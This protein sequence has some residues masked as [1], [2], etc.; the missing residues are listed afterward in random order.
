MSNDEI[1]LMGL[2][3]IRQA[4]DE[5]IEQQTAWLENSCIEELYNRP[6]HVHRVTR[7]LEITENIQGRILDIGCF[8]GYVTEKIQ[9]Q[10]GKKVICVD[11][12]KKALELAEKRGIKTHY[13]DLDEGELEFHDQSFDC[14]VAGGILNGTFDPDAVVREIHRV[15]VDD[16]QLIITTPNLASLENRFRL[17]MGRAPLELETRIKH[18]IGNLRLFTFRALTDLL[19]DNG[20][21][22]RKMESSA[23]IFPLHPI[24]WAYRF[25]VRSKSNKKFV[26]ASPTLANLFPRLGYH[27]IATA[28][29]QLVSN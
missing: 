29:K 24:N 12:I 11:R 4:K 25:L 21:V 16:G 13:F 2:K 26:W 5:L 18:G 7:L 14:V 6:L 23:L 10:G 8:E 28:Q 17:L 9:K 15:L 20:F 27:I 22:I 19:R 1:Q 3:R